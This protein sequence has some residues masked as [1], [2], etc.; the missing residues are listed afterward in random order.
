MVPGCQRGVSSEEHRVTHFH[1]LLG[2]RAVD[3]S[4]LFPDVIVCRLRH[5]TL[6]VLVMA[7]DALGHLNRI[8]TTQWEGMRDVV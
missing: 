5:L 3:S 1:G 4:V 6:E 2:Y 7:I 8:S